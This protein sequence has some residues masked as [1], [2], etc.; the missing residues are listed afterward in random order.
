M[1]VKL[2]VD[3]GTE[4]NNIHI[5]NFIQQSKINMEKLIALKEIDYSNSMVEA[6]NKTLK[7]RYLFPHH[8]NNKDELA[9]T[10]D[11][12]ITDYNEI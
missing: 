10:L 1:N 4:N 9:S 2:I 3:G 5:D 6:T 12:G 11:Y 8:P 7:Y